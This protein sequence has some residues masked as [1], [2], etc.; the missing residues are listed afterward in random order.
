VPKTKES[1]TVL[2]AHRRFL[3]DRNR[4]NAYQH[5]LNEIITPGSRV[6]DLGSGTGILGMLAC[7]AGAAE[8]VAVE[9]TGMTGL[10][11]EICRANGCAD[12]MHFIRGLST[13]IELPGPVDVIVTDQ[14]NEFCFGAGLLEFLSDAARR[15][16]APDGVTVPGPIELL[17]A[18]AG[19]GELRGEIDVWTQPVA[20]LDFSPVV[21]IAA[22]QPRP[23]PVRREHL[24][25]EP[26]PGAR[27]D[28][29]QSPE[30]EV[31][32]RARSTVT[33]DGELDG[34]AGFFAAHLAPNVLMTNS[35][36]ANDPI[37]RWGLVF[38]LHPPISVRE[39]DEVAV[40]IRVHP[41]DEMYTWSLS[42]PDD[43]GISART[44][45]GS[46]F[47]GSLFSSEDLGRSRSD[48][49]PTLTRRAVAL[50]SVID[51]CDGHHTIDDI[52]TEIARRHPEVF[53]SAGEIARA[54][55]GIVA[56]HCRFGS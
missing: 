53:S 42:V 33:R 1:C 14:I 17:V 19:G 56:T 31:E 30:V 44:G 52:E 41:A 32:V 37:D 26:V 25:G 9:A 45:R 47:L 21:A 22:N 38:P 13:D 27:I 43:G 4:V 28:A 5:A 39:G 18:P 11:R 50:K 55:A 54:V 48:H 6:L 3:S 7:K 8:V 34:I 16:L 12:R 23:F 10:A 15:C 46:S 36:A 49:R 35:P 51:L 2:E 40:D 20:D 29:A 24:L